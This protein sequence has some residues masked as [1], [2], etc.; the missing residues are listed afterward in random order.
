LPVGEGKRKERS[1]SR[2]ECALWQ[3]KKERTVT[4]KGRTCPLE[5]EKGKNGHNQGG[6][7][8]VGKG[9]RKKRSQS[10]RE[11]ARWRRKKERTVTIKGGTC[12]LAEEKG[13]NGHNQ[14]ENVPVGEGKR[15]ERSQS[16]GERARWQ[17]KKER[18]VTIK[19]G[20]C[21]FEK[22][23]GKNGH[24]QEKNVPVDKGKS[25]EQSQSQ[26][27]AHIE[28]GEPKTDTKA[29]FISLRRSQS[30]I[31]KILLNRFLIF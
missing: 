30:N 23:K 18:T 17:R 7:V 19:E 3:R 1:Q 6:N 4:I 8:P 20:M 27:S 25:K 26:V 14:G 11:C 16:R 15:K 5:K 2:E 21:P 28:V 12:P 24:N 22:E 29:A 9:K 13:K 10:R 31:F